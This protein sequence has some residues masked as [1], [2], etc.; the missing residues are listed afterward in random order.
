MKKFEST[1]GTSKTVMSLFLFLT[2]AGCQSSQNSVGTNAS[3]GAIL[4]QDT[5]EVLPVPDTSDGTLTEAELRALSTRYPSVPKDQKL[6]LAPPE[7]DFIQKPDTRQLPP[8]PSKG[9]STTKLPEEFQTSDWVPQ[10]EFGS[11]LEA[12]DEFDSVFK[13]HRPKDAVDE[14]DQLK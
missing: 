7:D 5:K 2:L 9:P 13:K 12:P 10:E 11:D 6:E 14:S 3:E 4:A 1:R 8:P